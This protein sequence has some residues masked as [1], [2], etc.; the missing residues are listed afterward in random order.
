MHGRA[1]N[2][3]VS[4]G[5]N[6]SLDR[7]ERIVRGIPGL[8]GAVIVGVDDARWGEASVIVA[9]RGSALRRSE[10]EQLEHAREA[11]AAEIGKPARPA[12]MILVDEL[13]TLSSGKPDREAIRRVAAELR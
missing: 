11:V 4:G 9:E 1:D 2:V 6:I 5:I 3:I 7:V 12:R 8:T 13:A 10:A